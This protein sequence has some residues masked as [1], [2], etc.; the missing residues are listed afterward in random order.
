[1]NQTKSGSRRE[2]S[3]DSPLRSQGQPARRSFKP[4]LHD[5]LHGPRIGDAITLAEVFDHSHAAVLGQR[6]TGSSMGEASGPANDC[7]I[8]AGKSRQ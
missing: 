7:P 8:A 5:R 2:C 1:M 6:I 4:A 3:T